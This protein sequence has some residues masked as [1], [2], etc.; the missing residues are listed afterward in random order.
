MRSTAP[1]GARQGA[2]N[3]LIEAR[4]PMNLAVLKPVI[5][6][7]LATTGWR[8]RFTGPRRADLKHA[9]DEMG[10]SS[11]AIDRARAEWSRIDL[12][13]NADP[14]EAATLR[15]VGRQVNFFHG[16]A[17]K[18]D[19]DCP[20]SL[21]IGFERYDRVAFPN[22]GRLRSYVDAGIV[23]PERAVLV[24]YPKADALATNQLRA[25]DAAGALGLNPARPTVIYAPTFSPA[26]S[27]Q[28]SGEAIV[29]ALCDWRVECHRQASRSIVRPGSQVHRRRRLARAIQTFR[30]H[31][32]LHPGRERRLDALRAGQ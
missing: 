18:Y 1:S 10:V 17:G 5:D 20:A 12:Y 19:L 8:L 6:A 30:G 24:G 16:V 23:A 2:R 9:F 15:R 28:S 13:I 11:R 29:E 14:W 4:T 25:R 26:A 7:L 31:R 22:E 32:Q 27:L 21:P 3:V